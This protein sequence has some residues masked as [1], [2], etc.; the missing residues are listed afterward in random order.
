MDEL[1][2][3]ILHG[4]PGAVIHCN[5][6]EEAS[7]LMS[8]LKKYHPNKVSNWRGQNTEWEVY[9]EKTVYYVY[10]DRP[11]HKMLY[12]HMDALVGTKHVVEFSDLIGVVIDLTTQLSDMAIESLFG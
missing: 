5:T 12:G 11:G 2:M 7:R 1:N 10:W 8:Y 9:R 3:N 6:E 4:Y